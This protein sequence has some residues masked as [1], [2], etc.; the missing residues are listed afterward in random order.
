MPIKS[1]I[2]LKSRELLPE[3][4]R[5]RRQIHMNPELSFQEF[6]TAKF[7]ESELQKLGLKTQRMADK[8]IL[9]NSGVVCFENTPINIIYLTVSRMLNFI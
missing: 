7:V 5:I 8:Q 2:Q 3:L 4:V 9:I 6:Q 1:K